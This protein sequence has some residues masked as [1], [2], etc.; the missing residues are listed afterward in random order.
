MNKR[1]WQ[2]AF[3]ET[4]EDFRLH[5]RQTLDGLEE[6][7][8]KP[9]YKLS[10]VLIAAALMITL[11]A[12]AGIAAKQL[13]IFDFL[14][15]ANPIVPLPGAEKLVATN[16][17]AS[18]NEY[19][20]LTVEEAVFDGQGVL[21]KCR[22]SPKDPENYALFDA[23]MQDAPEDTY[24]RESVPV[25]VDGSIQ[26]LENESGEQTIINTKD[27]QKVL[28][29]G[30]EVEIPESREEAQEAGLPVYSADGRLWYAD[31][32]E[33]RVLGRRDGKQL[34]DYWV[35]MEINDERIDLD[36]I[37]TR[38]DGSDILWWASAMANE[39]LDVN[40]LEIK[41][42]GEIYQDDMLIP[43]GAI[44]FTL[45]KS[46]DERNYTFAPAS[47]AFGEG[48]EILNC[49]ISCTK[50]RGYLKVD[51]RYDQ[52]IY[53]DVDIDFNL[54]DAGG[55]P[56]QTGSGSCGETGGIW[57]WNMEIQSFEEIPESIFLEARVIGEDKSLGRV[58]CKLTEA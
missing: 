34:L 4:P 28:L 51:F 9:K 35:S 14:D 31:F 7:K 24:I 50:V 18:E 53:G 29:N 10:T 48:F 40:A 44:T 27:E 1:D 46:E 42:Q 13:G 8:V 6:K 36:V 45:P 39:I 23:F 49:S 15:T 2:A 25:E 56:I 16:L 54:Y 33:Y 5:L 19:A 12:G 43:M 41:A 32:E 17:G 58:E 52:E 37:D 55:N 57:H 30:V 26:A 47:D 22:L 38:E 11:L 3:G 21:V 20:I